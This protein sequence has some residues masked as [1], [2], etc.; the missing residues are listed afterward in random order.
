MKSLL[1]LKLLLAKMFLAY[2]KHW[3]KQQKT[4]I[5]R[6]FC[7]GYVKLTPLICITQLVTDMKLEQVSGL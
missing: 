3:K 2:E 6:N 4:M 1:Q 5:A 7:P